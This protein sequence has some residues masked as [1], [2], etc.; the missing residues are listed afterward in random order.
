M[1][2]VDYT[3]IP[4]EILW[5]YGAC[6]AD[7]TFRVAQAQ[8]RRISEL[9]LS[10]Y[11]AVQMELQRVL[12]KTE[13]LGIKVSESSLLECDE[14]LSTVISRMESD[15]KTAVG[16]SN[17]NYRSGDQCRKLLYDELQIRMPMDNTTKAGKPVVDKQ[18]LE[19]ILSHANVSDVQRD[20]IKRL[21]RLRAVDK[22]HKTYVLGFMNKMDVDGYVHAT[23]KVGGSTTGRV[24]FVNPPLATVPRDRTF[25][26]NDND[27][28]F[29]SLRSMFICEE[30]EFFLYSDKSQIELRLL[31]YMS[32]DEVM[33]Q[34][35][36]S[37]KDLHDETARTI[38]AD[39]YVTEEEAKCR[40]PQQAGVACG[41][42]VGCQRRAIRVDQRVKAKNTNFGIPFGVT[43]RALAVFLNL[44]ESRV[45]VM[46]ERF[47]RRYKGLTRFMAGVK[48]LAH[49][50]GYL[51]TPFG[52]YRRFPPVD[53]RN[54]AEYAYQD[55]Q[56][57]NFLPQSTAAEITYRAM[58][59][60]AQ[61]FEK[62][63]MKS[64]PR[65]LVY[66]SISIVGPKSEQ[67][68]VKD[69]TLTE[70]NRPIKEMNNI[71]IPTDVGIASSWFGA[72]AASKKS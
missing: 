25:E 20:I 24:T 61:K 7:A 59:R 14:K 55:R 63:N 38:W 70:M 19:K 22:M 18:S 26:L 11:L 5:K 67:R 34:T 13:L 54:Y 27:K 43:Q 65:N 28:Y 21:L 53:K 3:K 12:L 42:C 47:A 2:K 35:F 51:R 57:G 32:G 41:A 39:E 16:A 44:P 33:I 37:G 58:I 66:D 40:K 1:S 31:A 50:R 60:I 17:F 68:D 45:E 52:R 72:E 15:I 64:W 46:M 4:T 30:D 69:I 29:I 36:E 71:V 6:D 8:E 49:T 10:Q 48:A 23:T 9:H 56:A 62:Y